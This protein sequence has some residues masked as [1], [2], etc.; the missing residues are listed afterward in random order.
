MRFLKHQMS[1]GPQTALD[2]EGL[3]AEAVRRTGL[4]D[5]GQ[6]PDVSYWL[7]LLTS[8]FNRIGI[9]DRIGQRLA[10]RLVVALSHRLLLAEK[11]PR[12]KPFDRP[13]VLVIGLA[14]S[15]T[16]LMH[17]LL[18]L[19]PGCKAPTFTE[20]RY[21]FAVS[22][23]GKPSEEAHHKAKQYCD[24]INR[25]IPNL[26]KLHPLYP[27]AP[28]EN[29][30]LL[31]PS[32]VTHA[33]SFEFLAPNYLAAVETAD[34]TEAWRVMCR[35]LSVLPESGRWIL[36]DPAHLGSIDSL[37][38][39]MPCLVVWVHRDPVECIPSAA[40]MVNEYQL[41]DRKGINPN[42][43]ISLLAKA[44]SDL[45]QLRK[46]LRYYPDILHVDYR[47][48]VAD[49]VA[50]TGWVAK[51]A[52]IRFNRQATLDWFKDNPQYKYGRHVYNAEKFGLT[53]QL[54]KAIMHG[55]W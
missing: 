27:D 33:F 46:T 31:E 51:A 49:P 30:I 55:L 18:S 4:D 1:N 53:N 6:G 3:I 10:D 15:G 34:M 37:L 26:K 32:L 47:N 42:L 5:F 11:V 21:P 25:L 12:L 23:G 54:I 28:E 7:G 13:P 41:S 39:V 14:R 8:D 52:G 50:V 20:A 44:A 48:L 16:S 22:Q 9:P 2:P 43:G 19:Q 35:V 40:S 45:K 38:E 17:Q 24:A 29:R 36:K